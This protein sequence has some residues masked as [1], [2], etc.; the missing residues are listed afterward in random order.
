MKKRWISILL[1]LV[2]TIQSFGLLPVTA[3]ETETETEQETVLNPTDY[4]TLETYLADEIEEPAMETYV[5]MRD[6]SLGTLAAV[7]EEELAY[8]VGEE[9][10]AVIS[11]KKELV[12]SIQEATIQVDMVQTETTEEDARQEITIDQTDDTETEQ[13]EEKLEIDPEEQMEAEEGELTVTAEDAVMTT[14]TSGGITGTDAEVYRAITR[15]S[16]VNKVHSPQYNGKNMESEV[17]TYSGDLQ[18]R[19]NDISLPGK[20]GLDLNIT[21]IYKSEQATYDYMPDGPYMYISPTNYYMKRFGLG[22]GWMLGFPSVQI[23]KYVDGINE[24][25][26]TREKLYYHDGN[27]GAYEVQEDNRERTDDLKSHNNLKNCFIDNVVFNKNDTTYSRTGYQSSYSY[28]RSDG[29]KE[30]FGDEGELIAIVDRFGNEILFDYKEELG[31]N[32]LPYGSSDAFVKYNMTSPSKDILRYSNSSAS[33]LLGTAVYDKIMLN[34]QV[35]PLTFSM[36]YNVGTSGFTGNVTI[37]CSIYSTTGLLYT[38]ELASFTP[39]AASNNQLITGTFT[40]SGTLNAAKYIR[41]E[42]EVNGQGTVSFADFRLS[43]TRK[44][45]SKI[46][47]TYGR[48]VTLD[49]EDNRYNRLEDAGSVVLEVREQGNE[50]VKKSIRYDRR[51]IKCTQYQS[52]YMNDVWAE[53][54]YYQLTGCDNGEYYSE[55]T[56]TPS[57]D[58]ME[59]YYY[60][61]GYPDYLFYDYPLLTAVS[62]RNSVAHYNYADIYKCLGSGYMTGW[63][64]S[65]TYD[66]DLL[67]D[68]TQGTTRKN[69]VTYGYTSGFYRDETGY[70]FA[71]G[72][73]GLLA[74]VGWLDGYYGSYNVTVN[75]SGHGTSEYRYVDIRNSTGKYLLASGPKLIYESHTNEEGTIVNEAQTF[76]TRVITSPTCVKTTKNTS[77]VTYKKYAYDGDS[78][79]PTMET[80]PLTEEEVALEEIPESKKITT[81]YEKVEGTRIFL[82]VKAVYYQNAD[83]RLEETTTY[84]SMQRITSAKNAAGEEICYEYT[85]TKFPWVV[86]REYSKD[87]ENKGDDSRLA[88]VLYEYEYEEAEDEEEQ[89]DYDFGPIKTKTRIG[90]GTYAETEA[91]YEPLY[92]NVLWTTDELG[93]KTSYT[94]D[95]LYRPVQILYPTVNTGDNTLYIRNVITYT[96]SVAHEGYTRFKV[97]TKREQ[98]DNPLFTDAIILDTITGYYDDN[99]YLYTET[100]NRGTERYVY[101]NNSR[102]TGYQ[103]YL[104][105]V[106]NTNTTTYTYDDQGRIE[107]VKD[108]AGYYYEIRYANNDIYYY[109]GNSSSN[110]VEK[111]REIYDIYG[112]LIEETV[113]A[114]KSYPRTYLT[115]TFTYD[116]L[117]NLLTVKDGNGKITTY[118][119]D[120]KNQIINTIYPDGSNVRT[121]YNKWGEEQD[122]YRDNGDQTT[123]I[124][125][126]YD[127]RGLQTGFSQKGENIYAGKWQYTYGDN[128]SLTGVVEPNGNIASFV[129]DAS[130]NITNSYIGNEMKSYTYN[131]YGAVTS[132]VRLLNG[133]SYETGSYEYNTLGQLTK[134]TIGTEETTYTSNALDNLTSVTTPSDYT[135]SYDYDTLHRLSTIE[136]DNKTFTY[137]YTPEGMV[138]TVTY[139]NTDVVTTY[140]Y[141]NANRVTSMVTKKGT[142]VLKEY[143]YTYDG[144]SN[145]TSVSGS[146]NVTY[147]YDDLNRLASST[148]DNTTITYTYDKRDNL[149][150]EIHT[151]TSEDSETGEETTET[152]KSVQYSYSGDNRLESK[153]ENGTTISY[154]YDLNGN[155]TGD[156]EGNLYRYDSNDCLI[157]SKVNGV[158]TTYTIGLDGY[159]SS[160]TTGN[161][162]TYYKL[163]ENGQVIEE[164]VETVEEVTTSGGETEEIT[165]EEVTT[166]TTKE[167]IWDGS[168]PIARKSGDTYEYFMFNAHGDVVALVSESGTLLDERSYD[169]WGMPTEDVGSGIGYAGEYYDSE[170]GLI[171]LRARYYQPGLRRF[172]QE[173]PARDELNWYSYCGNNPVNY[174]DPSGLKD[175]IYTSKTQYYV[176]NDRGKWDF[177]YPDRYFA[178]IDGIRYEANSKETV[179]LY[180]WDSFD[181]DFLNK[182]LDTL[183]NNANKKKMGPKRILKESIGGDLDFK[184]QLDKDTLYLANGILYNRNEAGN[185]A[186]A[187]YLESKN[188]SGY[189]SGALAQGGSIMSPLIDMNGLPRLDEEWDRKARWA[190]VKYYYD[191]NDKWWV[192]FIFYAGDP[193]P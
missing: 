75:R 52:L 59:L 67:E 94:Y 25:A 161:T 106:S 193:H 141:D 165:T 73:N 32:L 108:K 157:Y 82:P 140:E 172:T 41:F 90:D 123:A 96:K 1:V 74:P 182:T 169:D 30:Y 116:Q 19:F 48:T 38:E 115:N 113:T 173:D 79:L 51:K 189:I 76:D 188:V 5:E 171:Y 107:T 54:H 105:A 78:S 10:A 81:T 95:S 191:R 185:F 167:I 101:D 16:F 89:P 86:T 23:E 187:Y 45:L 88:E 102:V 28:T 62:H 55:I 135:V 99:G 98:A 178:E 128:G 114:T 14:S 137:T 21:R 44:M 68:G 132:Q 93:N 6:L 97:E 164:V 80:L 22:N 49:Y 87:P 69:Q 133:E 159:R 156:S 184:L 53:H 70:G 17:S 64:V 158:E 147:T 190:G 148:R 27:G 34:G 26:T 121:D 124:T 177:L 119:Y 40:P 163:N 104:D 33:S 9:Q 168:R 131:G 85:S 111:Y 145:I 63:K 180:N 142:T 139:P 92:G 134:K 110:E 31:E 118:Q 186:W 3:V 162:T 65:G 166:T 143:D 122:T 15:P 50:T 84:D 2:M 109:Y 11:A 176:E 4:A 170:T 149:V 58:Y 153:T 136:A 174:V 35:E 179:T 18:L 20:N 36:L 181:T 42:I 103:N 100:S 129:Y 144:N 127:D 192:Y 91:A 126:E 112:N 47:D 146:E 12:N 175:Y 125:R 150:G 61:I 8:A 24:E 66:T 37:N 7:S 13:F 138:A 46:T 83:T 43:P 120:E 154:E 72:S 56:Y 155:L 183:V 60:Y 130:N 29:T 117:G 71:P 39:S 57:G 160:K 151:T 152:I 77:S